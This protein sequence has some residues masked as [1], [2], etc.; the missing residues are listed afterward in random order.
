MPEIGE[1]NKAPVWLLTVFKGGSGACIPVGG[2]FEKTPSNVQSGIR[3][4]TV[5]CLL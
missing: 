2:W 4:N 1:F 3:Y 5:A